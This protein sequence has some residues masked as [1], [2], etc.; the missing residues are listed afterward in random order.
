MGFNPGANGTVNSL[1][2]Q[3]DGKILVGGTFTTVGGGQA[4]VGIARINANGS[5]DSGFNPVTSGVPY[6]LAAQ[7]DGKILVGESLPA[8]PRGQSSVSIA[9]LNADGSADGGFNAGANGTVYAQAMQ[10]DGKI[11]VGGIFTTL[12]GQA[13]DYLGRLNADGSLDSGFN[14][15]PNGNVFSLAVQA[16]GKVLVWGDFSTMA[17]HPCGNMA[18]LNADGSLDSGFNAGA[19]DSVFSLAL[20]VDGKI[21]VG[22]IF[23]ALDGQ[24]CNYL[25]RLNADGSLDSGF[26]PGPNGN[27]HSLAAQADGKVLVGGDFTVLGGQVRNEIGRIDNTDPATNNL[28]SDGSTIT[29]Q[30][31]GSSPEVSWTTA[32]VFSSATGWTNLGAGT[33]IPGG[34]QWTGLS[35]PGDA[36][37]RARGNVAGWQYNGS[38]W[39]VESSAGPLLFSSQPASCTNNAGATAQFSASAIGSGPITYQW[40]KGGGTLTDGGNVLGTQTSTLTLSNVSGGDAGGYSLVVSNA[41]GCVTSLVATLSVNDPVILTQPASQVTN[42]G[43]RVVL[44]VASAA[45]APVTYQWYKGGGGLSDGGNIAGAQTS[46]LTLSNVSGGD[47]GGY[48]LVVSN[49]FGCVTS[50]VATLAVNDPIILTQ[51]ASLTTNAGATVAFGVVAAATAPV[52]YQWL[53]NGISLPGATAATLSLTNV[54]LADRAAY[55][56]VVSNQFGSVTSVAAGLSLFA[57]ADSFNPGVN[58]TGNVNSLAVQTDGK[59]L[60]GGQTSARVGGQTRNFLARLN[61]DG[62]LDSRLQSGSANSLS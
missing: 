38:S 40:R 15:G 61:A 53:K 49:A 48:S 41:F 10:A 39:F 8:P 3:A 7:P 21:L 22:G 36:T 37:V 20:Q 60:V 14:P 32:D 23:T 58:A 43:G 13:C 44:G 19:S 42:A 33:R 45:S 12:D 28:I 54:Q 1:V 25:G 11:L 35:L 30:R 34:W 5:L 18:R 51:P 4:C 59:I 47:A 16:D 56:V 31:G 52:T 2:I 50:L 26:N 62:S 6:F 46:T 29:W 9:R 57:A 17:G 55:N 24:A 27:V